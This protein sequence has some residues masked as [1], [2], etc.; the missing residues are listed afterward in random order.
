M[1]SLKPIIQYNINKF[2]TSGLPE[3]ALDLETRRIVSDAIETY[4]P[5]KAQLNTHV[6]GYTRKLSRFVSNYQN[7]GKIPE[8]R[9]FLIGRYKT[10][11]ENLEA[12][13]GR[14]P[15][16]A[17][18]ADAMHIAPVE[19]E[20]LQLEMR[21]DLGMPDAGE[22]T[23]DGGSFFDL[24]QYTEDDYNKRQAIE[25]VYYDSDPID[26]KIIEYIFGIGGVVPLTSD[27]EIAMK[28]GITP[29]A[30]KK[31]KIKIA[32]AINEIL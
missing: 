30:L 11:Y 1:D 26:K 22:S 23:E 28:L 3:S 19:I 32:K 6:M 2:K 27:K 18:L 25:F 17:E 13:K 15:T 12:D 31:R 10:I 8:N 5:T 16:I 24:T 20:R 29:P 4:D 9:I 7:V 21:K 14:E